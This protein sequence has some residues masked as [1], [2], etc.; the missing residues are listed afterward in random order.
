[1]VAVWHGDRF[2]LAADDGRNIVAT[3]SHAGSQPACE[4]RVCAVGLPDTDLYNVNLSNVRWKPLAGKQPNVLPT[5]TLTVDDLFREI[6]PGLSLL[7]DAHG[8]ALRLQATVRSVPRSD[9]TNAR[10]YVEQ[11]G[12]VLPVD[13]SGCPDAV[14]GIVIGSTIDL[15]G[16]CILD[17]ESWRP[18]APFPRI[19]GLTVIL[20]YAKDV[21]VIHRPSWWTAS[22]SLVGK[23]GG[24]P[25]R[26]R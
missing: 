18:N 3:I 19:K 1:M 14:A 4:Q 17:T 7:P 16:I 21:R 11:D 15:T 6:R 8:K 2:L 5:E 13:V 22:R 23:S 25:S 26:P 20:R 10:M 12:H 9:F 24:G